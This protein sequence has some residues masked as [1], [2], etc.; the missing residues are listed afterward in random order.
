MCFQGRCTRESFVGFYPTP[1]PPTNEGETLYEL[2]KD[3]FR[4]LGLSL[5]K[6]GAECFDGASNMS[7]VQDERMFI[8]SDLCS[9][10]WKSTYFGY[11]R[12]YGQN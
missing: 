9:L 11:L 10:L 4:K 2:V 5:E 1:P 7:D 12:Y 8:I 3:V 6:V